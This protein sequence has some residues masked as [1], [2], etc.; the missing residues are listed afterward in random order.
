MD[1]TIPGRIRMILHDRMGDI[2]ALASSIGYYAKGEPLFHI[3]GSLRRRSLLAA[4]Y[5]DRFFATDHGRFAA[6][7]SWAIKQFRG[8]RFIG[9]AFELKLPAIYANAATD[10]AN[11]AREIYLENRYASGFPYERLVEPGSVVIDCGANIGAFAVFAATRAPGV[12]VIALEPEPG[13][14]DTLLQNVELNGLAD[15]ITCR[16]AGV[17]ASHT[18]L[19][20]MRRLDCF[21]MHRLVQANTEGDTV[22]CIPLDSLELTRCDLIKMDIEGAEESALR[23]ARDVLRRFHPRLTLAAYH[24][25][26][27][28]WVL[29]RTIKELAPEYNV[30]VSRD[31]HLYAWV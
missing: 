10:F 4:L 18:S 20:I 12:R 11:D 5:L 2:P 7:N 27:D 30:I 21:T 25:P 28:P 19:Q 16:R 26:S 24:K 23:G 29:S 6:Y 15:R 8:G 22:D 14:Y 13:I 1:A 17:A 31:A 3:D 9:D